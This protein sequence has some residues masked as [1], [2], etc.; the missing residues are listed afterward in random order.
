MLVWSGF[1]QRLVMGVLCLKWVGM[2]WRCVSQIDVFMLRQS[3]GEVVV[4]D[5]T[6]E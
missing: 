4:K 3:L 6:K 5:R 2:I 1:I